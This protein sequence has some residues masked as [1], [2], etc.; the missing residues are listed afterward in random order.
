MHTRPLPK[1]NFK[2]ASA[3]LPNVGCVLCLNRSERKL[4]FGRIA[5]C[6]PYLLSAG[7]WGTPVLACR[8]VSRADLANPPPGKR[9]RVSELTG[10]APAAGLRSQNTAVRRSQKPA[11]ANAALATNHYKEASR[12]QRLVFRSVRQREYL[13]SLN[14]VHERGDGRSWGRSQGP[15]EGALPGS[16]AGF[17]G[18]RAHAA[19][20]VPL[21]RG[22][23]RRVAWSAP[24]PPL[25]ASS[26]LPAPRPGPPPA[27]PSEPALTYSE[28]L[29]TSGAA[30]A[31][32]YFRGPARTAHAQR[33]PAGIPP[34][35]VRRRG[36]VSLHRPVSRCSSVVLDQGVVSGDRT[37]RSPSQTGPS[38][39]PEL[40]A[41]GSA[42]G[43]G[44]GE[45][46][47]S[48]PAPVGRQASQDS[49]ACPRWPA[50]HCPGNRLPR[51]LT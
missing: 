41:R 23:G 30:A 9:R 44:Q 7:P 18:A 50:G 49:L 20:A 38:L 29:I 47:G 46:W 17:P 22:R 6:L 10:K 39:W 28:R 45:S 5:F 24:L 15:A 3:L 11:C 25:T 37:G 32:N 33:L 14:W 4:A 42:R 1:A 26:L 16:R 48:A 19:A 13:S 12:R 8:P 51:R 31:A 35:A 36:A 21:H 43:S 2:G 40:P 27:A 34:R